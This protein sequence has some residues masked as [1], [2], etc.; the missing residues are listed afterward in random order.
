MSGG[1]TEVIQI[2]QDGAVWWLSGGCCEGG[3][4]GW[5]E[6]QR[7]MIISISCYENNDK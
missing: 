6:G 7:V 1:Y 3:W 4:F 2:G 5:M